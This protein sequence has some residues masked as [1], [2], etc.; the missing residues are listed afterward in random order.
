MICKCPAV[1]GEGKSTLI[2]RSYFDHNN[3][4]RV[5]GVSAAVM[6]R[7]LNFSKFLKLNDVGLK[8]RDDMAAETRA[9]AH[10]R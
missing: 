4:P 5:L 3:S 1:F 2:F 10:F 8:F 7:G 6:T 9:P